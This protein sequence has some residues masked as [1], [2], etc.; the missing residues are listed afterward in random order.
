MQQ[1]E[2]LFSHWLER[3]ARQVCKRP[4]SI[5]IAAVVL[6]ILAAL[7]A[8]T[9]LG[10]LNNTNDLIDQDSPDLKNFLSYLEEFETKD[11]MVVVIES[12]NVEVNKQVADELANRFLEEGSGIEDAF[13]KIDFSPLMQK[14]VKQSDLVKKLRPHGLLYESEEDLNGHLA[15]IKSYKDILSASNQGNQP[16]VNFNSL[17]DNALRKFDK[18]A[19][20]RGAKGTL[21]ELGAFVEQMVDK[22]SKLETDL[23]SPID[24]DDL[25]VALQGTLS[26][27]AFLNELDE[28]GSLQIEAELAQMDTT[29]YLSF[30]QGKL[31]L[32][33]LTPG[34]GN[35][36]A[37]D[38]YDEVISDLRADM[39]EVAEAFT[40]VQLGLTG[41][42]VMLDDELK[43]SEKDMIIAASLAFVL[44]ALF[45]IAAYHEVVRPL[46]ALL[47]LVFGLVWSLG[48]A[49][50]SVGH[51]N[52]ISQAF[53]LMLM[54]LGIDFGIQILGRY[55]EERL[56][57]NIVTESVIA[58]IKCTGSAVLVGGL[59]TTAAFL[60]MCFN[61]FKG[62]GE[63]GVIAGV[64]I[65]WCLLASLVLLPALLV[66]RD[67][68][69]ESEKPS[70]FQ[71]LGEKGKKVDAFLV[72]N[73]KWM[74]G[75][76]G[77]ISLLAASQLPKVKFDY[78]L[79][80]L[81]NPEMPAVS[82]VHRLLQSDADSFIPGIV[83]AED[84]SDE[85]QKIAQLMSYDTV[86]SVY[87]PIGMLNE[88]KTRI[89]DEM[90]AMVETF[91]PK[92]QD[93]KLEILA[94][95]KKELDSFEFK[96]DVSSKL[97]IEKAKN[98]LKTLLEYSKEGRREAGKAKLLSGRA[99]Q[100]VSIFE[101]LIP[102]LERSLAV[103]ESLDQEEASRRLSKYQ[104]NLFNRMKNEFTFLKNMD[105][106]NPVSSDLITVDDFKLDELD[107]SDLPE[108]LR[109]R[110][111]SKNGRVLLEVIAK[112]DVWE[113]EANV[114]F[115]ADL[116]EVD[117]DATGTPV[118]NNI[119][120]T[121]L[122]DSYV[123]AACWAMV[124]I[125]IMI[126]IHFRNTQQVL[127]TLLP[128]GVGILWTVGTM[129]LFGIQF[130]PANII[131]L[132]LVIG[133][134]VAYGVYVVDRYNEEGKVKLFSASTGKA[135]LLSALT[136]MTGFGCMITGE[137]VGLVS[138]G[139][140]MMIGIGY[141]FIAS[142]LIL[143][144]VLNLIGDKHK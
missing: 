84:Q 8:C 111:I 94:E 72:K 9:K 126:A 14:L 71:T 55:E 113:R 133:I 106:E 78:N 87:S 44:I 144:Q 83:I 112:E 137:Y 34:E 58:A 4:R 36:K 25:D 3:L 77:V 114:A 10:V 142:V 80:N 1:L 134:G 123:Q 47:A 66:L 41:E 53:I 108:E 141:C 122:K 46:L 135:I 61:E 129:G 16:A 60:T 107:T 28:Q 116:K 110:Y 52:I 59:I 35:S 38:P 95:L 42:P 19:Q 64:G 30:E 54:G 51:L 127:I 69:R 63:L 31:L 99:K 45:F 118:Q 97:D 70:G 104:I 2:Q 85:L 143:P 109:E 81:Q 43:Q 74:L 26:K 18:V 48:F 24:S 100:A 125:I 40:G 119:Y 27:E 140:L 73:P 75:F 98:N 6:F 90:E 120:I 21:D 13:Y 50:I 79:L 17:L 82:V 39:K 130:N 121:T 29:E 57:G 136:T 5:I 15:L 11:P 117:P 128:L 115:V 103:L 105:L 76:A 12:P 7:L 68:C 92:D 62:L 49:V 102:S 88:L 132:P 139:L 131:T 101:E 22:L 33:M 56:R 32:M 138:L 89:P 86:K 67:G 124:A 20:N 37:F 65:L 96:A 23:S 93:K 91:L